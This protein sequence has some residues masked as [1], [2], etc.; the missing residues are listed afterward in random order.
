MLGSSWFSLFAA[1]WVKAGSEGH[2]DAQNLEQSGFKVLYK[3]PLQKRDSKRRRQSGPRK[4]TRCLW[5]CSPFCSKCH[6][7][8]FESFGCASFALLL[9]CLPVGLSCFMDWC[10]RLWCLVVLSQVAPVAYHAKN[11]ESLAES[12]TQIWVL[13]EAAQMVG[14]FA[15]PKFIFGM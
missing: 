11:N 2:L 9:L 6:S 4:R 15:L 3:H 5:R 10:Q 1:N 7:M 13:I 12:S 8:L 14:D